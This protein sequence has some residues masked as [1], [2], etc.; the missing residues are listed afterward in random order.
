MAVKVKS[1]DSTVGKHNLKD[2]ANQ[3]HK[4]MRIIDFKNKYTTVEA[5]FKE[6]KIMTLQE[7]MKS[8][9]CLLAWLYACQHL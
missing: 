7:I 2:I 8:E 1:G 6:T 9:N 5:L 3:Q 4:A